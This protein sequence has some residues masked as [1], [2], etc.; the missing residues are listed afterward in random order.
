MTQYFQ[1]ATDAIR[2]A[3]HD[4]QRF[5]VGYRPGAGWFQYDP[6]S[7]CPDDAQP[8]FLCAPGVPPFPLSSVALEVWITCVRSRYY[9]S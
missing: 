3:S 4:P 9:A 8:E 7:G 2:S 1:D 5:A 6:A